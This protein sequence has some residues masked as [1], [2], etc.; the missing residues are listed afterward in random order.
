MW[1]QIAAH[2]SVQA[3][4]VTGVLLAV[5][6][7]GVDLPWPLWVTWGVLSAVAVAQAVGRA[8]RA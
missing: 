6:S 4:A 2:R 1:S 5:L 8:R 3:S 7:A